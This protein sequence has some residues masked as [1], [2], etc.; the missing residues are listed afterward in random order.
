MTSLSVTGGTDPALWLNYF[1]DFTAGA[2][3]AD[4]S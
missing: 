4:R 2:G 1:G 3:S